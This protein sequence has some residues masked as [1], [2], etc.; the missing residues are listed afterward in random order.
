MS[1][2]IRAERWAQRPKCPESRGPGSASE[3]CEPCPTL[4]LQL[5]GLADAVTEPAHGSALLLPQPCGVW[6]C[7]SKSGAAQLSLDVAFLKCR[8]GGDKARGGR[9]IKAVSL[10]TR[11]RVLE[12]HRVAVSDLRRPV[13]CFGVVA[14]CCWACGCPPK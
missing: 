1:R 2:H 3:L 10:P 14:A 5:S 6:T 12:L 7:A 8:S 13:P 4:P 11:K 9:R